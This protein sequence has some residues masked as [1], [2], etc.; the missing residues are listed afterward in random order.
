VLRR[1]SLRTKLVA[2]VVVLVIA[3]ETGFGVATTVLMRDHL[4]DELDRELTETVERLSVTGFPNP[5][6]PSVGQADPPTVS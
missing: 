1:L 5:S 3:A 4:L 6:L 2:T